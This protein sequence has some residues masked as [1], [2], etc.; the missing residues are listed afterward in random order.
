MK[1][2]TKNKKKNVKL[3]NITESAQLA[4]LFLTIDCQSID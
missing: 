3:Q 2:K 4:Q 1:K